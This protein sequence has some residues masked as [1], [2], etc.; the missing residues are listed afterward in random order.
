MLARAKQER[1]IEA[2]RRGLEGD[3]AVEFV[4]SSGYAMNGEA[5]ARHL[6]RLG[7][8][9][10][11][12]TLIEEGKDNLDVLFSCL[13]EP[14]PAAEAHAAPRQEELFP[15]DSIRSVSE[16]LYGDEAPLYNSVKLSVRMPVELYEAIRL[17]A[18]VEKKRQNQLIVELLTI[19]LS[20]LPLPDK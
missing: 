16:L 6:R 13:A 17:A 5:I 9:G 15:D 19:A 8:I 7:G 14:D 1:I 20:R 18:K 11:I 10:R 4:C 12:R 3:A 2:V